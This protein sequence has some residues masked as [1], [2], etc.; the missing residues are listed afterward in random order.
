MS[1][2]PIP[3]SAIDR[4]AEAMGLQSDEAD[5]FCSIIR[6]M[7]A[8]YLADTAPSSEKKNLRTEVSVDDTEGVKNLFSKFKS[9][10]SEK[11]R[12]KNEGGRKAK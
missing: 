1:V 11:T 3:V 9:Q 4:Y 5:R 6:L 2:G 7:D 10:N 8:A 12:R